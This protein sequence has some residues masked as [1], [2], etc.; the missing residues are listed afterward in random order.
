MALPVFIL[1]YAN[2]NKKSLE[3][4]ESEHKEITDYFLKITDRVQLIQIPNASIKNLFSVFLD[5]KDDIIGFHFSGHADSLN[6]YLQDEL[7]A[8]REGLAELLGTPP[9]LKFIFLNG[10][11]TFE[12]V[13]YLHENGI[14]AVIATN[15]K[16]FDKS[17]A[18]FA[19]YFY[20]AL[21]R[22][23]TVGMSFDYARDY[24]MTSENIASLISKSQSR[25]FQNEYTEE[26]FFNFGVAW[27]I[28]YA[29]NNTQKDF[30]N[31][32]LPETNTKQSEEIDYKPNS[33]LIEKIASYSENYYEI[34]KDEEILDDNL[35]KE[36]R[37]IIN[38]YTKKFTGTDKQY[39]ILANKIK[40]LMPFPLAI[41]FQI[42]QRWSLSISNKNLNSDYFQLLKSQLSFYKTLTQLWALTMLSDLFNF[43]E[44][45]EN[46][47]EIKISPGEF[48]IINHYFSLDKKT[49]NTF[50]FTTLSKSI[51]QVLEKNA[52]HPFIEEYE[53]VKDSFVK[54]DSLFEIHMELV[55]IETRLDENRIDKGE[56]ISLCKK[57]EEKL[58]IVLEKIYF[59]LKY[60]LVVIKK[61]EIIRFRNQTA[62]YDH[63]VLFL[64][65]AIKIDDDDDDD[66]DDDENLSNDEEFTDSYSVLLIKA[67]KSFTKFLNL[68]P[69]IMDLNVLT[70]IGD[71]QLFIFS[72]ASEDEGLVYQ[73]V[74]NSLYFLNLKFENKNRANN[75]VESIY[76]CNYIETLK[77]KLLPAVET[78][79]NSRLSSLFE[80]FRNFKE[81][82]LSLKPK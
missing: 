77:P 39:R 12:H 54:A 16:V 45:F 58:W 30:E 2:D 46:L 69:F 9:Q 32:V 62:K 29:E 10:C 35:K 17:A 47:Q 74:E 59:L 19:I 53:N 81:I 5:R 51:R 65:K 66:D 4:L 61:I 52:K 7:K 56:I 34:I 37:N 20:A 6:L 40:S 80:Q 15:Q 13:K 24:T 28:H 82:L 67:I 21:C 31:W 8:R 33:F 64:K 73:Q 22:S 42:M 36:F 75:N 38:F 49:V 68:S 41:K 27:G 48:E 79:I 11:A 78:K 43:L 50:D 1:A 57:V 26:E 23:W 3:Y 44:H 14:K 71:T 70:G 60:K 76:T 55:G 63:N 72:Y 25:Y 18:E